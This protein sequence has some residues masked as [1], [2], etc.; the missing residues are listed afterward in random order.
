LRRYNV[1]YYAVED[2][3]LITKAVEEIEDILNG[4]QLL[5]NAR[6]E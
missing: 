3:E 1:A 4:S 5:M 6:Q 2:F